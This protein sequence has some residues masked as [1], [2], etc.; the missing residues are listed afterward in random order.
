MA[1]ETMATAPIVTPTPIPIA[2]AVDIPP[3]FLSGVEEVGA[4]EL[5]DVGLPVEGLAIEGLPVEGVERADVSLLEGVELLGGSLGLEVPEA[6][7]ETVPLPD[8]VVD[9]GDEEVVEELSLE[10]C[11]GVMLSGANA[12]F[13]LKVARLFAEVAS[14]HTG[15]QHR[16][17]HV[18]NQRTH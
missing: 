11:P 7:A 5:P 16:P 15:C 6:E 13:A 8:T 2:V 14:L 9:A 4:D 18:I 1:P 17:L 10:I 3:F 12:A